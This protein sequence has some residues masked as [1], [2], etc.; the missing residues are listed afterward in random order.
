VSS[1][2]FSARRRRRG[3]RLRRSKALPRARVAHPAGQQLGLL[4]GAQGAERQRL[5]VGR[6]LGVADGAAGDDDLALARRDRRR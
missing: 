5:E 2:G 3:V 1:S 4:G 6:G